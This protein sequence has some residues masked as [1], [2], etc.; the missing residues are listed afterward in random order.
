V[1]SSFTYPYPNGF[2]AYT[3]YR[4]SITFTQNVNVTFSTSGNADTRCWLS[5]YTQTT[6]TNGVPDNYL[7][8]DD[9][10]GSGNNFSL[11]Y[12][13]VA[14]QVYYLWY[15]TWSADGDSS[16]ITLSVDISST[17]TVYPT[18]TAQ[19]VNDNQI[20]FAVSNRGNYYL[21][22]F[23]R[24]TDSPQTTIYDTWDTYGYLV[25]DTTLTVSSL[26]YNT[27]YTVNVGY[28]SSSSSGTVTWI[29]SNILQT[30]GSQGFVY[31]QISG[32]TLSTSQVTKNISF[33]VD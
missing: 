19:V 14:N 16:Y 20:S 27:S 32:I 3:L 1:S 17:P 18:Y 25:T 29:G 12:S 23:V 11:T 33:G 30:G 5:D 15:R 8:D 31:T 28:S 24:L 10:S 26:S 6:W 13:C 21:R 9:D 4:M 2:S 7:D 22:Y